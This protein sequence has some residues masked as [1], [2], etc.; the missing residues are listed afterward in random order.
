MQKKLIDDSFSIV[1]GKQ[2]LDLAKILDEKKYINEFIIAK[3]MNLT[4]NQVRNFLYRL[5]EHG[6]VSNIRKK[7]KKKGWYTYFWKI[8]KINTLEFLDKEIKKRIYNLEHLL[9]SRETKRFYTCERCNIDYSEE[10]ALLNNFICHDCESV[11]VLKDNTK[12]IN[13]IKKN[14]IYL[15]KELEEVE[16]E[17]KKNK[18]FLL[19]KR[20]REIKKEK[21]LKKQAK[22]K[23]KKKKINEK[24]KIKK[25]TKKIKSIKR[26]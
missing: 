8:E 19:K 20:E 1:L 16:E 24:K 5:F 2:G 11:L 21:R 26:K 3:K 13:E 9:K 17:I 4:I 23:L 22:E 14:I 25:K 6:L 10:N 18:D 7:D 12:E 15:K